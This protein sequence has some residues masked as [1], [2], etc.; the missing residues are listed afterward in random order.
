[1]N[2]DKGRVKKKGG[3]CGLLNPSLRKNLRPL[4]RVLTQFCN[5]SCWYSPTRFPYATASNSTSQMDL[6][7]QRVPPVAVVR[8]CRLPD[9]KCVQPAHWCYADLLP[10]R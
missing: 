7:M 3:K 2:F 8:M 6:W 10:T 1:M 9:R 4:E 5:I